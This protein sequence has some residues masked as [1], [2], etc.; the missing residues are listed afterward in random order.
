MKKLLF[1]APLVLFAN[2]IKKV[3]FIGLKHI[4][5]VSAKEI[6]LLHTN[7]ELDLE[8]V[9]KTIKRFYKYGYFEDIKAET[10]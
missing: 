7:D 4:S 3:E 9:D 1:L 5:T 2:E 6:S 10:P 8:K